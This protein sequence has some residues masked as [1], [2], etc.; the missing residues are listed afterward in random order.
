MVSINATAANSAVLSS[1]RQINRDIA[2]NQ[3][4]IGTGL[5]INSYS[6]NPALYSTAQNI[7]SDIKAQDALSSNIGL[8]KARA[9]AANAGLDKIADI[10]TK[11]SDVA[12]TTT[13]TSTASEVAVASAKI[14]SYFTQV[15]AIVAS[16]GF[17]GSNLLKGSATENVALSNES[18][19]Q[20]QFSGA[21]IET[22]TA[23]SLLAA[24]DS[25][26]GTDIA[27][28]STLIDNT[29]AEVVGVQAGVASFSDMLGSQLDFQSTL[30]GINEGALSSIVDANLEEEAAK[31]T[32]L[33]VKQQL[34]YQALSIGNSSSQNILRLFQ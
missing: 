32:A 9:D 1:L 11:M 8:S 24:A 4:R 27:A 25:A 15:T 20:I 33:Q 13:A 6:D 31:S 23:Y 10:L 28:L 17:Q 12:S 29:L 2:T 14:A 26:T 18:L 21:D 19:A 3:T 22:G 30:K 34:A 5:K 16:S 7:R